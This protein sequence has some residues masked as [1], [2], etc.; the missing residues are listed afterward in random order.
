MKRISFA[1][2]VCSLVIFILVGCGWKCHRPEFYER[3]GSEKTMEIV[4]STTITQGL[5]VHSTT[6]RYLR[7]YPECAEFN[8]SQGDLM[9]CIKEIDI[10]EGR[11]KP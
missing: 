10:K 1:L 3:T 2:L 5:S 8:T 6:A 7:V 4:G 9:S 11:L